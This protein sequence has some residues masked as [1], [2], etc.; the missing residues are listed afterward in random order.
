[1]R[2]LYGRVSSINLQKFASALSEINFNFDWI[3]K[4]SS[5][6]SIDTTNYRKINPSAQIP[7]VDDNGIL[8]RQSNAIVRY[9]AHS[10]PQ[11]RLCTIDPENYGEAERWM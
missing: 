3:N 6:G 1:M 5:V 2:C 4:D 10:Y 7:T 9:L 8:L 11:A